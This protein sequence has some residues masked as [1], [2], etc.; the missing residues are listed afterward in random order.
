MQRLFTVTR[1]GR[2]IAAVLARD[3]A[4]AVRIAATVCGIGPESGNETPAPIP[5]AS[6]KA[7]RSTGDEGCHCAIEAARFSGEARLAAIPL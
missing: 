4:D 6:L 2:P 1:D 3:F 7:R 5:P